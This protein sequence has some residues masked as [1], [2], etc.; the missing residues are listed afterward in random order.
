MVLH[1]AE[2]AIAHNGLTYKLHCRPGVS[3]SGEALVLQ[4]LVND[5][6]PGHVIFDDSY[7]KQNAGPLR[8][9]RQLYQ[10]GKL[11]L[12]EVASKGR[13]LAAIA[14]AYPV[15][16]ALSCLMLLLADLCL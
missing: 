11:T 2:N 15:S 4:S 9:L 14:D 3:A 6:T 1:L 16:V 7:R 10:D 12:E 5:M 8:V 13:C